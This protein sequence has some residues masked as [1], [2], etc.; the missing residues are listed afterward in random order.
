VNNGILA[1]PGFTKTSE[2]RTISQ[3]DIK[4]SFLAN[5]I[6]EF[7]GRVETNAPMRNSHA[8]EVGEK[9]DAVG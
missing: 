9:N 8:R 2:T 4:I 5:F 3:E 6:D 7:G 1:N